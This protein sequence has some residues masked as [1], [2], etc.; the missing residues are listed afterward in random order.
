MAESRERAGGISR[1][2]TMKLLTTI[3]AAA[4]VMAAG[5]TQM[6]ERKGYVKNIY[7]EWMKPGTPYFG[8]GNP[9]PAPSLAQSPSGRGGDIGP[10][11]NLIPTPVIEPFGGNAAPVVVTGNAPMTTIT[12]DAFGGTRVVNYGFPTYTPYRPIASPYSYYGY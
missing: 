11:P 12:K 8:D 10:M 5:C 3:T 7:G 1:E 2:T 6:M 4:L 9:K